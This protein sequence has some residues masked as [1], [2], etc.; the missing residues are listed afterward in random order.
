MNATVPPP[1]TLQGLPNVRTEDGKP[2]IALNVRECRTKNFIG[3][4]QRR[5]FRIVEFQTIGHGFEL[6]NLF[7]F[8]RAVRHSKF[9]LCGTAV[10]S[11]IPWIL[12]IRLLKRCCVVDC[13]MDIVEWPFPVVR[14][15]KWG[16]WLSLKCA[17]LIL[18]IRS[19][20][21]LIRKFG[22]DNRR[23]LFI[24]SC[25]DSNRVEAS[26]A[27]TPR[28]R[29]RPGAFLVCCSGCHMPH[30]LER[31]MQTFESL[32]ALVP[33][34]ELLLIGD[35]EQ[36]S[37]VESKRFARAAGIGDRIHAIPIIESVEDFY[38]T[39]AQ[40]GLWVATMGDDT[41][42]GRHEFRMELLEIGLL[43]RP[44]IAAPTP[45]L[46][47]HGL[48]D[49]QE[50]LYMDPSEP[51]GSARKI[52]DYVSNPTVLAEIGRRLGQRVRHEYSL[53]RAV[54]GLL[55]GVSRAG[56]VPQGETIDGQTHF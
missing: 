48:V 4:L 34:A 20:A 54:D 16:V 30:R 7:A 44:V 46:V 13:P 14:H 3:E 23:V 18:T 49:G 5:G 9:V 47:E 22:L 10:P 26:L 52:A 21:Y 32:L 38:A 43:G 19:R 37:V 29:P 51:Q 11:Q 28:Y 15:W 55:S 25:P 35:L 50:I 12:L 6:P 33:S 53:E 24:E 45:G 41:L 2:I 8:I 31:F 42:Q 17:T 39:V 27:G 40:C 56:V 36:P 1:R